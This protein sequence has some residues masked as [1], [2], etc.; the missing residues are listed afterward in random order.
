MLFTSAAFAFLYLPIV[1]LFFYLLP[2]RHRTLAAGWLFAAS[3]FFYGYWMP[4]FV[5]LLLGSI[6]WNY[7]V[8]RRIAISGARSPAA[9]R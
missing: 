6:V 5:A 8:G 2:R 9:K 7:S 1:A 4:E 3:V